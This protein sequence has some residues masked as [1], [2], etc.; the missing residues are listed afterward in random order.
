MPALPTTVHNAVIDGIQRLYALRLEGAP[1]ADSLQA[2]AT[3]W[4]DTLGYK[5]SWGE[6]DAVRVARAFA[7]LCAACRRWPAPAQFFDHLPPPPPPPAL[8]AP[9]LTAEEHRANTDWLERLTQKLRW[10]RP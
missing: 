7:G 9:V 10:G 1:P 5:R 4:L 8:P 6:D 3:V 2:T